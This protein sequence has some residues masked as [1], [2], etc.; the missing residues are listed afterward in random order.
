MILWL[1]RHGETLWNADR[2]FQ[3]W[4]DVALSE[5]GREQARLLGVRL[6]S[7]PAF[8]AVYT[9]D[10]Q[11]ASETARLLVGDSV[12]LIT[13]QRLREINFGKFEGL[14]MT[15]I[16]E[17]YPVDAA[18]WENDIQANPHGGETLTTVA[19]R[20]GGFLQDQRAQINTPPKRVMVVAH[21]G[22]LG[23]LLSLAVGADPARW[24]QFRLLNCTVNELMLTPRGTVLVRFNDS[25]HFAGTSYADPIPHTFI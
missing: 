4:S 21:G 16:R 14:T 6:Q 13:D 18:L 1:I 12:P 5:R 22:T 15:E 8:D 23:I 2:R 20:V 9:S 25:A 19:E 3:G 7:T 10:R 24:W 17:R 11:R